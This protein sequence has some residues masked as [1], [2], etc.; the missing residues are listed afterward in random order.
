MVDFDCDVKFIIIK[1]TLNACINGFLQSEESLSGNFTKQQLKLISQ[2]KPGGTVI[3]SDI[4]AKG[5][6]GTTRDLGS[7][8]FILK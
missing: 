8:S 1:F 7:L 2:V 4:K 3:I 6:D 5:T